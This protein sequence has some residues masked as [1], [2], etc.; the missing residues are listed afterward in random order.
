M[1]RK[2]I[3]LAGKT[4]VV[5]LPSKWAKRYGIKKGDTLSVEE[6]ER[7]LVV[8]TSKEMD[9]KKV[10]LELKGPPE[11]IKRN[12][13]VAYK[14]GTDEL[15]LRFEDPKTRKLIEQILET[16]MGFEIITQEEKSCLVKS[17]ATAV[18]EEFDNILRRVFL[19]L[20]SMADESYDALSKSQ[21]SRLD[22]IGNSEKTINKLT[23]FCKRIL[24]KKG[25]KDY[26]K[27]NYI[28][29]I[30]WEIERIADEYSDIC[31]KINSKTKISSDVLQIY[32]ETNVL[33]RSFYEIFYKFNENNGINITNR[34]KALIKKCNELMP[35]KKGFDSVIL[36]HIS[37]IITS[38][39][40]IAGPYYA[41]ILG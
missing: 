29:C 30:V 22:E 13:D 38:T 17:V 9:I 26:K 36:H 24:N 23:N 34:K 6:R 33:L 10:A 35:K 37:N 28:Y 7:S 32:K 4:L 12:I 5:S 16:T 27:S 14:K 3:Q 40:D 25:Y 15:S 41:M 11:F 39:Y 2:A 19:T 1:E 31:T 18:E 21:I 8:N 20:L